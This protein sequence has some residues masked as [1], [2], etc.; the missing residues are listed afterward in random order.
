MVKSRTNY[1]YLQN[2]YYN[3]VDQQSS[4]IRWWRS[5]DTTAS[6][7]IIK[8][9]ILE[10]TVDFSDSTSLRGTSTFT[11]SSADSGFYIVAEVIGV[12]SWTSNNSYPNGIQ[13]ISR[14]VG[15][16]VVAVIPTISMLANS[17]VTTTSGR[18]NWTSTNQASF[19]ANGV[20]AASGTTATSIGASGLSPSTTYTG[21]VVV[22]SS[23]GNQAS[24]NYSLTTSS[25]PPTP[26]VTQI[27]GIGTGTTTA[28]YMYFTFTSTNAASLSYMVY[29]SAIS[30]D[31]PWTAL[32]ARLIRDTT[33]VLT[34]EVNSRNGSTSNWYYVD[35]IPYS[36]SNATGT[37]GTSRTSRPRRN[38]QTTSATLYP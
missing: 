12:S 17:A 14:S 36:G 10:N 3:R 11:T 8:E 9:Q 34:V 29:R 38:S 37:A 33:G 6:G 23:T 20:F 27:Q 32:S 26:N 28:P 15:P 2:Y 35:V 16:I 1:Y 25:P 5:T 13:I 24:A 31:G 30:S 4:K 22:T 21:T 19:S 18:I 7:T